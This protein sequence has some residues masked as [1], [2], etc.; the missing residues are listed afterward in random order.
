MRYLPVFILILL[1]FSFQGA[2][3][4]NS[5]Y[6][7]DLKL[8]WNSDKKVETLEIYIPVPQDTESQMME[9]IELPECTVENG[10]FKFTFKDTDSAFIEIKFRVQTYTVVQEIFPHGKKEITDSCTLVDYNN[11]EIMEKAEEITEGCKNDL[12]KVKRIYNFVQGLTYD[13]NGEEKSASWTL[14]NM[15]GDCTEFSFLFIALCKAS[16]IDARP[17]W[18]WLPNENS[19]ISHLWAEVYLGEW[20]SIDLT[21]KNFHVFKPHITFNEGFMEIKKNRSIDAIAIYTFRGEKPETHM[22]TELKL[23]EIPPWAEKKANYIEFSDSTAYIGVSESNAF[24]RVLPSSLLFLIFTLPF[25][26][27]C[28]VRKKDVPR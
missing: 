12:E 6:E 4:R 13:F 23:K 9:I 25:L 1:F 28:A 14:E 18:G 17:V 8:Y 15:K 26:F 21:E 20:Y 22:R 19:K 27:A 11:P 24:F 3:I 10:A 5:A 2:L 7:G 16:G